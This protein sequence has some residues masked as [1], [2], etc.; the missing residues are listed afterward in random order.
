MKR[1]IF[2]EMILL[3]YR[4]KSAKRI[5]F[6][7]QI[8]MIKGKNDTGK[9]SI[10]KSL[11][12]T[13]GAEPQNIHPEWD[14]ADVLS[15][16]RFCINNDNYSMLRY[17]ELYV[18]FTEDNANN[19]EKYTVCTSVTKELAPLLGTIFD[20]K[21]N[22]KSNNA[23]YI[24]AL[25]AFKFLPYYIDQ[26][27]SWLSSWNAFANLR[28]F[29]SWQDDTVEYHLGVKGNEWYELFRSREDV[30]NE[31]KDTKQE[32]HFLDYSIQKIE[33]KTTKLHINYSIDEFTTSLDDYIKQMQILAS[34]QNS[35]KRKILNLY[36]TK[37]D[38]QH[39]LEI[40]KVSKRELQ[41]DVKSAR[42][43]DIVI[44]CPTCNAEYSN[45]IRERFAIAEDIGRC[46]ELV[47]LIAED[48][49]QV[50]KEIQ[51][52]EEKSIEI[53][54][55]LDNINI[56]LNQQKQQIELREIFESKGRQE[57]LSTLKSDRL[58]ALDTIDKMDNE[59][60]NYTKEMK[61]LQKGTLS[62]TKARY[63]TLF[64]QFAN[65]LNLK[66]LPD[67][68]FNRIRPNIK[69]SGS[70][71]P[72]ALLAYY[73]TILHLITE[74]NQGV[75]CPFVIDSLNQQEQDN[76]NLCAMFEMVLRSTPQQTQIILAVVDDMDIDFE[77]CTIELDNKYK[78]LAEDEYS[79]L[80]EIVSPY[81]GVLEDIPT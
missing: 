33:E 73:T 50:E 38:L 21:L 55:K 14:K 24:Q 40:A 72:R 54:S 29:S 7:P 43:L 65:Q 23:G 56:L 78:V 15:L 68:F 53:E 67:S 74:A 1:A 13:F 47:L 77:G 32:K 10:L 61:A 75:Y 41:K 37:I 44:H 71:L 4:E 35:Y 34:E 3:S 48:L 16:V 19:I 69:E 42:K 11:Y 80:A 66:K 5:E 2:K 22:L 64:K 79:N 36:E 63:S 26:D 60:Y 31:L 46:D 17:N 76:T 58:N 39:Q 81:V 9:S 20:F 62:K 59:I 57:Y 18:L 28:Q 6:H 25:P 51:S 45:S 52:M 49:R 27:S 70:D 12:H 30:K 8:T